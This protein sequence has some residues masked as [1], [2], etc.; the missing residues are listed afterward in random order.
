M[1]GA[2]P[3]PLRA[4]GGTDLLGRYVAVLEGLT[5]ET[6][7]RLDTVMAPDI[8]FRDPFNAV[9]GLGPTKA[10]FAHLFRDC[11]D[12]VFKVTARFEDDARA[13]LLWRMDY[14]LRRGRGA[15]LRVIEGMSLLD[16]DRGRGVVAAHADHWD[17]AGQFYET[18]PVIGT[19]LR[20]I[21]R[22]LRVA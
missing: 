20:L 22:R 1:V 9:L 7:D 13:A 4:A 6:L 21:R 17:A 18:L 11:T 2:G 15:P 14:R 19:L 12:V 16:L 8:A 3:P 5:A 10:I